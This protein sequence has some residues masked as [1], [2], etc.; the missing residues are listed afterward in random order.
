[1]RALRFYCS[2]SPPRTSRARLS[3]RHRMSR[4]QTTRFRRSWSPPIGPIAGCSTRRTH[5]T[6]LAIGT[7]CPNSARAFLRLM[8]RPSKRCRKARTRRSTRCC[9]VRRASLT[10]RRSAIPIFTCATNMRTCSIESTAFSCRMGSPA[11]VRCSKPAS[12]AISICSTGPCRRSTGCAPRRSSTS[13]PS[14]ASSR[15]GV[16]ISMPAA[17]IRFPRVSSTAAL[18]GRPSFS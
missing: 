8:N 5:S 3:S 1:M 6:R 13:R 14:S 15:S 7:C 11:W 18:R 9:C 10:I 12:S 4:M 17:G 16:S 2:A